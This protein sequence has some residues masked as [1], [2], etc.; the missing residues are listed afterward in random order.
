[1]SSHVLDCWALELQQFSVKFE[2]IQGK[3]NM[4]ADAISRLG[5]YR[6]YQDNSSEDIQL[7]LE[8]AVKNIIEE[9]HHINSAPTATTSNKTDKVNLNLLQKSSEKTNSERKSERNQSKTRPQLHLR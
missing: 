1:M 7:S 6:I 9:I 4:V 8:D 3:K 2:C 5:M